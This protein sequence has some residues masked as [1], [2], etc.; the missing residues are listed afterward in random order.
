M[1]SQTTCP[2]PHYATT[3]QASAHYKTKEQIEYKIKDNTFDEREAQKRRRMKK[4]INQTP[5]PGPEA[6]KNKW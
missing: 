5:K 6:W 3:V 1:L 2:A 4:T